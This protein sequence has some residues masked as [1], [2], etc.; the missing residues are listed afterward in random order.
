MWP[1]ADAFFLVEEESL[2][3]ELF[4]P[5]D[6][7]G[8]HVVG[9]AHSGHGIDSVI[10]VLGWA[11]ARNLRG[12]LAS[13][14]LRGEKQRLGTIL[15]LVSVTVSTLVESIALGFMRVNSVLTRFR[16]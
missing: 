5:P 9:V 16:G 13:G 3:A 15:I 10:T 8:A 7:V 11:V 6:A 1:I 14:R 4:L 2:R 12:M